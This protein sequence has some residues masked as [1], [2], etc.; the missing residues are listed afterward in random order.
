MAIEQPDFSKIFADGATIGELL[1][2][3]DEEYLRGWGYLGQNEPPPMEYFNYVSNLQDNKLKYLFI[4][5]NIRKSNTQY[6]VDDIVTS[7]N[8]QSKF[9]LVCVQEGTT[10]SNEP[11]LDA[12]EEGQEITDGTAKWRVFSKLASGI[13]V[14]EEEPVNARDNSVW[15]AL[16]GVDN[17]AQL[18][19]QKDGEWKQVYT[20]SILN[21]VK[22]CPIKSLL[23]NTKYN[24][25]DIVADS[26]CKGAFLVCTGSGT[27]GTSVASGLATA[28]E[29]Q[30]ITDG[31]AKFTVH[32]FK[33]I[34][35]SKDV[36][37]GATSSGE[38][39]AGIVPKPVAGDNERV[40][41]GDGTFKAVPVPDIASKDEA[42]AQESQ[43]NT[44]MMTPLRTFQAIVA[45]FTKFLA[46]A[47]F[48]GIVR[49]KGD[50][51]P[52][53]DANDDSVPTTSWVQALILSKV[54]N[55]SAFKAYIVEDYLL[56]QNGYIKFGSWFGHLI[57]QW[58]YYVT[59]STSNTASGT[60]KYPIAFNE[61]FTLFL[62]GVPQNNNAH[63]IIQTSKGNFTKT[64]FSYWHTSYS[65]NY[66]TNLTFF[67]V[68]VGQ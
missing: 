18:K 51:K 9:M 14:G 7:P 59:N 12:A 19:Y 26:T 45:Y 20:D 62:N 28:S 49:I 34:V 61:L 41:F 21:A 32:F 57:L 52:V 27:T 30:E 53:A 42:E 1:N 65:E 17:I 58:G 8:L 5:A 23:R 3:P 24:V 39:S 48:T 47:V 44:K 29:G 54:I 33:E 68:A 60:V 37:K 6:H 64:S 50:G 67:W 66:G 46:A 40:L 31:T 4:S 63:G 56:E 10:D 43:N 11:V 38:G 35:S 22:D 2:M 25:S 15:L 55:S 16:N 13:T 36:M